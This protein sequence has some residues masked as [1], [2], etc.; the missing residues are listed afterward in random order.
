MS[1]N[2]SLPKE[3]ITGAID[4]LK[5]IDFNFFCLLHVWDEV[6]KTINRVNIAL[7]NK[8]L[9]IDSATKMI[10]G[11]IVSIQLMRNEGI[12]KS[13]EYGQVLANIL[14]IR[15]NFP[16][17]RKRKVKRLD[18]ELADDDMQLL[19]QDNIFKKDIFLIYDQILI[20]LEDRYQTMSEIA[21]DFGFLCGSSFMEN[22]LD[23]IQKCASDLSFKYESDL[24]A[25]DFSSEIKDFKSQALS[26]LP[27]LRK[28]T[29][30][31]LLQLIHTYD[32]RVEY[33]NVEIALRIFL[34][35]PITVA[36]CERSFSKLKLIK[37]YLR[38]SM[39]QER[40]SDLAIIS[41][42]HALVNTLDTNELI[43]KFAGQ[44]ARKIII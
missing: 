5:H 24:N 21:N 29:P 37:N 42:E 11:L 16:S 13:I 33:P 17:K 26:L 43:E 25:F 36:T 39:E 12:E 8:K 30:L 10:K 15:A 7:Q 2:Q 27:D 4:L 1:E 38:S 41:I 40:I 18:S 32:L 34:T 35:L 22:S 44:K 3:S 31:E 19:S 23:Y 9:T 28:A 20:E 14:C 6:L